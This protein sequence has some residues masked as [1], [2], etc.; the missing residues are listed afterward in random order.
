MWSQRDR[1]AIWCKLPSR[2][3]GI[4]VRLDEDIAKIS[5]YIQQVQLE[6]DQLNRYQ[7]HLHKL[8]AR[9]GQYVNWWKVQ[10]RKHQLDDGQKPNVSVGLRH[11]N[12]LQQLEHYKDY[13]NKQLDK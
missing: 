1:C 5:T 6:K 2:I 11:T 8:I 7:R 12:S 10:Q 13:Y 3:R 9:R 4:V